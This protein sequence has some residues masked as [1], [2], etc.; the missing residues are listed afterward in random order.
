MTHEEVLVAWLVMFRHQAW[1]GVQ[2]VVP[3]MVSAELVGR[4]WIELTHPEIVSGLDDEIPYDVH[5]TDLGCVVSDLTAPEFG[6]DPI[7]SESEADSP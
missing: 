7:G 1:N 2:C 5:V 6:I 4:G 3:A